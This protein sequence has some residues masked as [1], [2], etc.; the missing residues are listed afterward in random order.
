M[1]EEQTKCYITALVWTLSYYY[2]GV[3]SWGWYY[4]HHYAP[5]ISDIKNFKDLQIEL[6]L[7]GPFLPFQQLLAVLPTAS[8]ELLPKAYHNLMTQPSST[9]ID[10]YPLDFETDLNGK[11]QEWEALV[12]IPFIDEVKLITAMSD[13][14]MD[15]TDAEKLRNTHGPMLQYEYSATD[16][17]LLPESPYGQP[18]V[19]HVFCL[20]TPI[21]LNEVRYIAYYFMSKLIG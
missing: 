16:L 4:P 2:R 9:I 14:N 17:G 11:K 3:C 15:L 20:E 7:G 19:P 13:C 18:A 21:P 10:Y 1:L 5:Y 8:K 6:E 12:L